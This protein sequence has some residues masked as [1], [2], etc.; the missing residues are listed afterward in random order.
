MRKV[1]VIAGPTAVGK[2]KYT[3]EIG[4][5]LGGEI[6]SCDSMQLYKGMDIGSAKPSPE[7]MALCKHHLVDIVDPK[8]KFSVAKYQELALNAID[9]VLQSGKLPIIEG[10][11][12]L[13]L[14]SILYKMDFA[15]VSED[16]ELRES[17]YK[18]A[19]EFGNEYLYNK[20][21]ELDEDAAARIHPNNVKKLVRAIEGALT[22]E[23]IQDIS[24]LN[25]INTDY[26]FVLI[27]LNR[28]RE[29]LYDR[30]NERVDILVEQGLFDEVKNLMDSGLSYDDIS[31]KGI[32]YKEVISFYNGQVSKDEAIDNIKKN[33]RHFAK[34]QI[35]WFKRYKDMKWF[36]LSDYDNEQDALSEIIAY[37]KEMLKWQ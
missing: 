9:E 36:N 21:V 2:T 10:G 3:C 17:L 8:E 7:E 11:T 35:T 32:G 22:G 28:D 13:Y 12:G 16:E 14:N 6:I 33:T 30:I 27:G 1:L 34:R 5:T 19:E 18:E 31:M 25:E 37:T 29:E 15:D 26:D 24:K 4:K 23:G 20:L